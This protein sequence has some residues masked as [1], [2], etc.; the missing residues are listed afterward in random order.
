M[1]EFFNCFS[2]EFVLFPFHLLTSDLCAIVAF[3]FSGVTVI[4]ILGSNLTVLTRF[5]EDNTTQNIV[6][7]IS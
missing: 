7:L 5:N 1:V 4:A 3:F 6:Q 2:I